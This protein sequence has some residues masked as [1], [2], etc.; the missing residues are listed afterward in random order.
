[1]PF[2]I[3]EKY[4]TQTEKILGAKLPCW[5]RVKMMSENGGEF[6]AMGDI[7]ELIPVRNPESRKTLK[8]TCNDIIRE[9][10]SAKRYPGF[11]KDGITIAQ[12]GTGNFLL[13]LQK[14]N[15]LFDECVYHFDHETGEIEKVALT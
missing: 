8:R 3:K 12:N 11:P 13:L 7:W 4:I 9:T 10:E 15:G 1:M 2:P 14:D 5:F 6:P